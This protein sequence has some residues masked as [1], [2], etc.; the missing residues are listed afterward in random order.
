MQLPAPAILISPGEQAIHISVPAREY[1]PAAQFTQFS[2]VVSFTVPAV[3]CVQLPEPVVLM[4]PVL[5]CIQTS[6]PAKEY[7][8]AAQFTQFAF[9][10]SFTVPATH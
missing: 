5:H 9:V 1:V 10:V 2:F 7:V 6:V 4:Y 8:P 3:H